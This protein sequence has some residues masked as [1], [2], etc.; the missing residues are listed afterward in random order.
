[1]TEALGFE[2]IQQSANL[3]LDKAGFSSWSLADFNLPEVVNTP[4]GSSAPV[5]YAVFGDL[6][7]Q[8]I[9]LEPTQ[10]C[11]RLRKPQHQLRLA[12]HQAALGKR[13]CVVGVQAYDP[14]QRALGHRDRRQLARGDFSPLAVRVLRVGE[15]LQLKDDQD[16][17][18]YGYS[19]GADVSIQVAHTLI[20]DSWELNLRRIGA[21]DCARTVDRGAWRVASAVR[22]SSK[23]LFN[24]IIHGGCPALLEAHQIDPD[25]AQDK[26]RAAFDERISAGV[27]RYWL[28]HGLT[29]RA[30]TCG[31]GTAAS[32]R[33]LKVIL[34]SDRDLR[35]LV[36][37][38]KHSTVC[39]PEFIAALP[40][41]GR[42][43]LV[44]QEGD[45]SVDSNLRRSAAMIL[46]FAG[47][48]SV[49]GPA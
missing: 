23:D 29:N 12:A 33:Q 34:D 17:A 3:A 49:S 35:V 2:E 27:I 46:Y 36:G 24:N 30:I 41:S 47:V 18:A 31:F 39:P 10:Y 44:E 19:L 32:A 40:K 15:A 7:A 43:N 26:M 4:N 20:R 22:D 13:Y 38:Q 25:V 11:A 28:G 14:W 5:E 37:R 6:G 16:V 48:T 1:M 21:I 45:H 8:H 9:V 42:L